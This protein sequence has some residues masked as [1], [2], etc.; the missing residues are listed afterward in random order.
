MD[1]CTGI[2]AQHEHIEGLVLPCQ[3][4]SAAIRLQQHAV[5]VASPVPQPPQCFTPHC[6]MQTNNSKLLLLQ[7]LSDSFSMLHTSLP[8]T[9]NRPYSLTTPAGQRSP[10]GRFCFLCGGCISTTT[11]Q[12][13][14]HTLLK[15]RQQLQQLQ[16]PGDKKACSEGKDTYC[17]QLAVTAPTL[18]SLPSRQT[19][20]IA[21]PDC[22]H[23]RH[24]PTAHA[25]KQHVAD[26]TGCRDSSPFFGVFQTCVYALACAL[27]HIS[28]LGVSA[29]AE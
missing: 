28:E 18:L 26:H 21:A 24:I 15:L 19:S 12:A 7:A 23:N 3:Q 4:Q 13:Q 1:A 29:A 17:R 2:H 16:A 27:G 6:H 14:I 10:Q 9:T 5:A 11:K 25:S 8:H 20:E 22:R